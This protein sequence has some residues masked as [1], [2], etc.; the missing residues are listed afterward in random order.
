MPVTMTTPRCLDERGIVYVVGG[1]DIDDGHTL[2]SKFHPIRGHW[3]T[4]PSMPD[5]NYRT[6][7]SVL[8][9]KLYVIGGMTHFEYSCKNTVHVYSPMTD[10]W[11]SG[12]PMNAKRKDHASCTVHDR[13][14]VCGGSSN[15][16]LL[17]TCEVFE[18]GDKWTYTRSMKTARRAL[19]VVAFQG[20]VWVLGGY[21]GDRVI[22]SV[23][24]YYPQLDQWYDGPGMIRE[25]AG[26]AAAALGEKLYVFGGQD[27]RRTVEC[28]EVFY[29]GQFT[30]LKKPMPI[31]SSQFAVAVS[32][33]LIYCFCN[34]PRKDNKTQVYDTDMDEWSSGLSLKRHGISAAAVTIVPFTSS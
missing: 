17:K 3:Q 15:R 26:H 19:A 18:A 9:G 11:R 7:V 28:C 8:A 32:G 34:F 5:F 20:L 25:R 16:N 12:A 24:V 30:A 33:R 14:Y 1:N 10:E 29:G 4:V 27:S 23:E 6:S 13:I 31:P 21:T 2:V 22:N